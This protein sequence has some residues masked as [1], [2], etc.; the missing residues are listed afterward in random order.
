MNRQNQISSLPNEL[1]ERYAYVQNNCQNFVEAK[2]FC[3]MPCARI[4][5]PKIILP[6][7]QDNLML[8][9]TL[10]DLAH[11]P[12]VVIIMSESMGVPWARGNLTPSRHQGPRA[13]PIA[14]NGPFS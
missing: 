2:F 5:K 11:F 12:L 14:M 13:K 6:L 8:K 3:L 10:S 4:K 7:S 1:S 9:L